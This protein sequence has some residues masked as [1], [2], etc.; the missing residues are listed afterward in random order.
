MR[1]KKP[2]WGFALVLSLLL[3]MLTGC[4]KDEALPPA[5]VLEKADA[6]TQEITSYHFTLSFAV[7]AEGM[8]EIDASEAEGS[9]LAPDRMRTR[10]VYDEGLLESIIIGNKMYTRSSESSLWR[11][12][13]FPEDPR[14]QALRV[15]E[16]LKDFLNA[17]AEDVTQL[18]SENIDG[19]E[20]WRYEMTI[21]PLVG[22]LQA[23][24]D[25]TDPEMKAMRQEVV[26]MMR[27]RG[28][29]REIEVWIGKEDYL[30]RQHRSTMAQKSLGDDE[31]GFPNVEIP[32][33]TRYTITAT[34]K[35]FDFNEPVEIEAPTETY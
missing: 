26:E 23:V 12:D 9:Y 27:E 15:A 24:E 28:T 3:L 8:G 2:L 29:T 34:F 4:S 32:E 1:H 10:Q 21:D 18:D 33:G 7:V 25:E 13:E 20:C 19:A 22:L 17:P 35:F 11:V 5:L 6:A 16:Y 30:L 14:A 31:F